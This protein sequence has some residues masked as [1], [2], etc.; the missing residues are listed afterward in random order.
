MAVAV[1]WSDIDPRLGLRSSGGWRVA[2]L[3]D[4][5]RSAEAQLGR[6][7]Q[8]LPR[9]SAGAPLALSLPTLPLPPI[10]YT[11]RAQTD[12]LQARLRMAVD[13]LALSAVRLPGCRVVSREAL[14]LLSPLAS[15]SDA[16]A[17]IGVG[18]P[19]SG[20][21]ADIRLHTGT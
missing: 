9:I 10:S 8:A 13:Q 1:E 14:D 2:A 16:R 17:D 4:I 5:A 3:E 21:H 6:L 12:A 20:G 15:R 11:P 18:F 7:C 19:Y